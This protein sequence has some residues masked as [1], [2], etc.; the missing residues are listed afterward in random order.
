MSDTHA[1]EY[2]ARIEYAVC[3]NLLANYGV[4]ADVTWLPTI[5][6]FICCS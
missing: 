1:R 3:R 5:T 6:K 4:D 2:A